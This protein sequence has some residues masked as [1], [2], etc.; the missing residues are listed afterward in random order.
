[1]TER[2]TSS[3]FDA[4]VIG[5]GPA[6]SAAARLL[7]LSGYRVALVERSRFETP[8]VG[9][10]LAPGVQPLLRALGV[11]EAFLALGPLPS[12]G[13]RSLWGGPRA[14][15]HSHLF[16]AYGCGWHVD[17]RAFDRMLA[18]EA[19]AAGARLF[20]GMTF[21]GCER[22]QGGW[23]VRLA[24]TGSARCS[25]GAAP[26][27]VGARIVIDATGRRA[28]VARALGARPMAFDGLVGIATRWTGGDP[29]D[30]GHLVVEASR[31]GWWYSAPLPDSAGREADSTIAMFLTDADL[32]AR[33][34]L[35]AL[36][37]WTTRLRSAPATHGRLAGSSCT[38]P[39]R[40]HCA[41][42][43]RLRRADGIGG[44]WLA[45]GDAAM[46][47]DPISGSGVVRA[48]R[49]ARAAADAVR[50]ALEG[51][52]GHSFE[53]YEADRDRDCT[54]YLVERARY[55]GFERRWPESPFWSRRCR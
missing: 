17:R 29:A 25:S 2:S 1:V 27:A 51:N 30:R 47:V 32:C 8:R 24:P 41:R 12:W 19:C 43:H 26:T 11:W 6:G 44:D 31:D 50:G 21:R 54:A 38:G 20:E 10:S 16:N 23:R 4:A 22:D 36:E 15:T 46:A 7:A 37:A 55:Y 45:V 34:R 28:Q 33:D 35:S 18:R 9:E 5:A 42:S 53:A 49:T 39:T 13:T 40:V 48:L 52:E 14:E 3:S